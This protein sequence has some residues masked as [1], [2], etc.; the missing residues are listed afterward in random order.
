MN[1][2]ETESQADELIGELDP[3]MSREERDERFRQARSK[4][5]GHSI[6]NLPYR[7]AHPTPDN[8]VL[9][10]ID[11]R[12]ADDLEGEDGADGGTATPPSPP[13]R[14]ATE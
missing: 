12:W 5:I 14:T 2:D 1:E 13:A 7:A 6:P 8:P 9:R 11:R 4:V 10:E 3:T